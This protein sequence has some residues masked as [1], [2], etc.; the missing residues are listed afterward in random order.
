MKA[1][2]PCSD[3]NAGSSFISK[4]IGMPESP[5]ETIEKA[6]V[7]CLISTGGVTSL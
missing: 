5:V 1:G 6:L 2:I 3:L 7:P 4:D